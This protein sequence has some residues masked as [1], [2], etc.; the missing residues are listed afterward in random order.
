MPLQNYEGDE[1]QDFEAMAR[2]DQIIRVRIAA[3][4]GAVMLRSAKYDVLDKAA[5]FEN[6]ILRDLDIR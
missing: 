5:E 6:W 4:E 3:L 2:Q 1:P